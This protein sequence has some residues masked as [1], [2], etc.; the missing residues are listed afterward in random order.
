[1]SIV[2]FIRAMRGLGASR[3][4]ALF[5]TA[6]LAGVILSLIIFRDPINPLF[7]YCLTTDCNRH[8]AAAE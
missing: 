7:S 6:P 2:L 1:M 4:S 5:G 8:P 3:T